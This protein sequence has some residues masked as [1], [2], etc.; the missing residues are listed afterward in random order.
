MKKI[1]ISLV[2]VLTFFSNAQAEL[3]LKFTGETVGGIVA[4]YTDGFYSPCIKGIWEGNVLRV[5]GDEN[6]GNP[7]GIPRPQYEELIFVEYEKK[8][9][10]YWKRYRNHYVHGDQIISACVGDFPNLDV[11]KKVDG[12][13]DYK[14]RGDNNAEYLK[15]K[16]DE[17]Y[18]R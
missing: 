16:Y 15:K 9:Y 13:A 3:M 11:Y 8:T 4:K 1:V 10:I 5:I 17:G 18:L 12:I 6:N 2:L 7:E 14:F